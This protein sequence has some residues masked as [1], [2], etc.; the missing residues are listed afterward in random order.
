M[1]T[2]IKLKEVRRFFST[3]KS[4]YKK[5]S[6][7]I[8]KRQ[9]R[10]AYLRTLNQLLLQV[11]CGISA[12]IF[13]PIWYIF[14]YQITKRIYKG[15]SW[16]E[17]KGLV[18]A[19]KIEDVKKILKAN[20][21][22]LYWLWTFGDLNDPLGR[23]ELQSFSPNNNFF[24]RFWENAI[25]NPR[26]TINYTEFRTGTIVKVVTVIDTRDFNYMHKSQGIGDSPDG[27]YFKWMLD[28][29]GRWGFIYE[30]NNSE[31][32]FYYGNVGL[33]RKDIG[34]NGRFETGYRK[35]DSSYRK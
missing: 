15:T 2:R 23:G 35:T 29:W 32:I 31:N 10:K 28:E 16:Q 9:K 19:N 14:R 21:K 6:P 8:T 25:R 5:Q 18:D 34:Q 17:I 24:S 27:I 22:F 13:Y 3:L 12:P 30:D 1:D 33:L 11:W 20:G 4:D 26:F 7:E